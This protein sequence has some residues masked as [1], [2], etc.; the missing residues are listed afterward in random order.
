MTYLSGIAWFWKYRSLTIS[1]KKGTT[2]VLDFS[3]RALIVA[4]SSDVRYILKFSL[5]SR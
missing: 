4:V 2:Q 5:G 1:E 3:F